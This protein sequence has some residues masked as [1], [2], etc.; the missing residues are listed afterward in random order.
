MR[1]RLI[2]GFA[3]AASLALMNATRLSIF[4]LCR[5]CRSSR[6]MRCAITRAIMAGVSSLAAGSSQSPCGR[7][8][9]P[10]SSN[11]PTTRGRTSPRQL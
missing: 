5:G 9:S 4:S 8:H 6:A 11:F 3:S 10:F 1:S 2:F 7:T